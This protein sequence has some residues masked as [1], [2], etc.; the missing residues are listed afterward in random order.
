MFNFGLDTNKVID[1]IIENKDLIIVDVRTPGEY[2]MGHIRNAINIPLDIIEHS[3]QTNISDKS[4]RIFVYC[5][6]GGRSRMATMALK[7]MGYTNVVNIGA[8]SKYISVLN[9]F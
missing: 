9:N 7:H 5:Q 4:A 2:K 3:A 1:E 6:S 8:I